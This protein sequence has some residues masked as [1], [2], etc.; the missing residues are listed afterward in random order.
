MVEKELST[1]WW[2]TVE[3]PDWKYKGKKEQTVFLVVLP[4][5]KNLVTRQDVS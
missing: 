2:S 4:F 1:C 5:L 3:P